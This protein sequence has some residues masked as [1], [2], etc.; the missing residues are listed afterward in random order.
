VLEP[1]YAEQ[2]NAHGI[3][4]TQYDFIGTEIE[5]PRELHRQ[6]LFPVEAITSETGVRAWVRILETLHLVKDDYLVYCLANATLRAALETQLPVSGTAENASS[7]ALEIL[8][9]KSITSVTFVCST[10]RRNDLPGQ[11]RKNGV[12]VHEVRAYKT[13]FTSVRYETPYQAL[14]F[15]SPSGVESFLSVNNVSNCIAFC[16]GE[17]TASFARQSGFNRVQVADAPTQESIV[18]LVLSHF[19]SVC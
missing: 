17:T 2:L 18:N 9:D 10:R 16:I 15:F 7:L 1:G 8:K 11:L 19:K 6:E 3:Q 5:L 14:I 4:L 13:L 12:R